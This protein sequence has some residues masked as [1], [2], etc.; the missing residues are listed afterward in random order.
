MSAHHTSSTRPAPDLSDEL[1]TWRHIATWTHKRSPSTVTA[2]V[3]RPGCPDP[4]GFGD[5]RWVAAEFKAWYL[6]QRR[7][8]PPR[9][10]AVRTT[11][12]QAPAAGLGRRQAAVLSSLDGRA[13][14]A[15]TVVL[16]TDVHGLVVLG[17]RAQ[18]WAEVVGRGQFEVL[19]V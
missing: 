13:E 12:E 2:L 3:A 16:A 15:G 14:P 4:V 18:L 1:W 10:R 11:V 19:T 7:P 9:R 6:T 5:W 17:A 8:R